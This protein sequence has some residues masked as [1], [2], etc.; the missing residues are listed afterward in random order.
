MNSSIVYR[1]P[2]PK[3]STLSPPTIK[4]HL[5]VPPTPAWTGFEWLFRHVLHSLALSL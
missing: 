3:H 5:R 1:L 4:M 2:F